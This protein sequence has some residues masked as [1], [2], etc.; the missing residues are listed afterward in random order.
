MVVQTQTVFIHTCF[1]VVYTVRRWTENNRYVFIHSCFGLLY[2]PELMIVAVNY[3]FMHPTS[4]PQQ[5]QM[6]KL[7]APSLPSVG[8][9]CVKGKLRR[10]VPLESIA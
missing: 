5:T 7:R 1:R 6:Y 2:A 3:V 9:L 10:Q 8:S 4:Y